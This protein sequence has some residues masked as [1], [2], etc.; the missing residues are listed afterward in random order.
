MSTGDTARQT[1]GLRCETN[2]AFAIKSPTS[3]WDNRNRLTKVEARTSSGMLMFEER[4][5]FG[6]LNRRIGVWTDTDGVGINPGVQRWR[7]KWRHST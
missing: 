2:G 5:M 6:V 7:D 4:Y 1:G 3:T